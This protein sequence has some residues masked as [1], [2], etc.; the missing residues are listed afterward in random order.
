LFFLSLAVQSFSVLNRQNEV[1]AA[2]CKQQLT[3]L[4]YLGT[5]DFLDGVFSNWQAA[6]LQL[7]SLILFG[8]IFTQKGASHSRKSPRRPGEEKGN[9]GGFSWIYRNSLSLAFVL[10]F[11]TAFAAHVV[12]GTQ[13]YNETRALTGEGPV[14]VLTYLGTGTFWFSTTEAWQA[15]VFAIGMFLLLTIYFR[16]EGSAESKPVQS[17]DD[18]TGETNK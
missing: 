6:I 16:Q 15:E 11:A 18:E 9:A 8:S 13:S 12:F 5:G 17:Q 4:Q 10:L 2:H 3:Y 7:G 14:P 1:L